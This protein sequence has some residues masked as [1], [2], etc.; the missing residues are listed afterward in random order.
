MLGTDGLRSRNDADVEANR[1]VAAGPPPSVTTVACCCIR[2]GDETFDRTLIETDLGGGGGLE[3]APAPPAPP[4]SVRSSNKPPRDELLETVRSRRGSC[5]CAWSC[6]PAAAP[7]RRLFSS[8]GGGPDVSRGLRVEPA[9]MSDVPL[10]EN[11]LTGDR[12]GR[13]R[14]SRPGSASMGM[15]ALPLIRGLGCTR[16]RMGGIEL[17]GGGVCGGPPAAGGGSGAGGGERAESAKPNAVDSCESELV[18]AVF[19]AVAAT[20]PLEGGTA[21]LTPPARRPRSSELAFRKS[22]EEG[23]GSA[24]DGRA[25]VGIGGGVA[26]LL[27]SADGEKWWLPA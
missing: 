25:A 22:D 20:P 13:K 5:N 16:R 11:G 7:D 24:S 26:D 10:N 3:S 15:L 18:P 8:G 6:S 23:G 12:V 1:C 19:A 21:V 2:Y 9:A 17:A 27:R 14:R 4:P